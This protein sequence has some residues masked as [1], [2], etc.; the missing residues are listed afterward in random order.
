MN[1][2]GRTAIVTGAARGIGRA[3]C[4]ELA[5]NGCN[6][7]FNYSR[8]T[9]D[10]EQ[11]ANELSALGVNC[12]SNKA[13]V[14]D[15]GAAATMVREVLER[16]GTV[17]YLVNNAGIIRDKLLLRMSEQD[18]DEVI[19]TNL[20]GAFNFSKAVSAT[21]AKARFGSM[22]NI[23]SVSG[24]AGMPGQVNYAASKA[25]LIGLTKALAKELASRN[26]TINALALGLID[27]DMT[28]GMSNE[29][30]AEALK[31]IPAGR[32]GTVE[33]VAGIAAFLLSDKARYITGQVIQMDGGL[34][35]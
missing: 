15:F 17:D 18:W 16:F 20:K 29:Y 25:G 11:L 9:A 26:I 23:T 3:V 1:F 5:R 34:A 14:G 19:E 8:S 33:E 2:R 24:I 21:M 4:L 13:P 31:N 22:L 30:K 28:K 6:I 12:Y 32:F 10:A 35:I 27:T 7:A